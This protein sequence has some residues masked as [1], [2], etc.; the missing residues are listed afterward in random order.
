MNATPINAAAE[1]E[2][3]TDTGNAPLV[4]LIHPAR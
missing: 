2:P 3:R 1:L 4:L